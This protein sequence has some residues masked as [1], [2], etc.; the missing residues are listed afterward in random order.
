MHPS[1]RP[2]S[3][4]DEPE[5][6]QRSLSETVERA[7]RAIEGSRAEIARSKALGQSVA[8]LNGDIERA[9]EKDSNTS[10]VRSDKA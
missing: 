1:D 10:V 2:D 3:P 5:Q 4:P 9:R 6:G 7:N 8:D